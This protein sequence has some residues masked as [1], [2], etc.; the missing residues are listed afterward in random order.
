MHEFSNA[1][2]FHDCL[3][4]SMPLIFPYEFL[5]KL[6]NLH[7]KKGSGNFDNVF[8]LITDLGNFA[9]G[10]IFSNVDG[11]RDCHTE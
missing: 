1:D 8:N 11:P 3:G 5:D 2:L 10:I 9:N 4:Y 6:V 7:F